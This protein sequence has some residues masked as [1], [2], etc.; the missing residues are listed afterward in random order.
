[1]ETFEKDVLYD[2]QSQRP[3]F[4]TVLCILTFIASGLGILSSLFFLAAAEMLAPYAE[5]IP[6]LAVLFAAGKS[7]SAI[8]LLLTAGS[9]F[10]AIQMFQLK[11]SG[12][13]IYTISNIIGLFIPILFLG[14]ELGFSIPGLVI[15]ALF[16]G[17]YAINLK[18][19]K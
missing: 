3:G 13:F 7:Y 1:M 4:L 11:K 5:S 14:K 12:F 2:E 10:G 17:L 15:V 6:N 19:M 18:H 16:I 8:V 9:L